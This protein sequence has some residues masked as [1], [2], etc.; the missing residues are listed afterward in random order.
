MARPRVHRSLGYF[1]K[2]TESNGLSLGPRLTE[3]LRYP[4]TVGQSHVFFDLAG[5]SE[6]FQLQ[7]IDQFLWT[8]WP[9][10]I[11]MGALSGAVRVGNLQGL[12]ENPMG[13]KFRACKSN[14]SLN[15]NLTKLQFS[16]ERALISLCCWNTPEDSMQMAEGKGELAPR[17]K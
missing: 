13:L 9:M 12:V 2:S 16:A 6:C 5:L 10:A 11:S 4:L 14:K 7:C 1:K 8:G 17:F 3:I 15:L